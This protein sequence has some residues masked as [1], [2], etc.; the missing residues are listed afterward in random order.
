MSSIR[1]GTS[2]HHLLYIMSTLKVNAYANFEK[3]GQKKEHHYE[4]GSL[5]DDYIDIKITH[6]G[7]THTPLF[8]IVTHFMHLGVCYT[9]IAIANF[10]FHPVPLPLVGGHEVCTLHSPH[11]FYSIKH[12]S[13]SFH[14]QITSLENTSHLIIMFL[15]QLKVAGVVHAVGKD[16]KNVKV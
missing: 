12:F 14:L 10:E 13:V 4:L 6:S 15:T 5:P 2:P 3:G 8:C 16:V 9:D 7:I 1:A 11:T